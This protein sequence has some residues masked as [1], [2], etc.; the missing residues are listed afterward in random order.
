MVPDGNVVT[1]RP[2]GR[3][4]LTATEQALYIKI[5]GYLRGQLDNGELRPRDRVP[6]EREL[7]DLFGCS[8]APVRQALEMLIN[9]GRI[10]AASGS[11][12]RHVLDFTLLE[13]DQT[14]SESTA[15]LEARL[16]GEVVKD[17]WVADVEGQGHSAGQQIEVHMVK[18]TGDVARLLKLDPGTLV[19]L[20]H[21]MRYVDGF[22]HDVNDT[23]YPMSIAQNTLIQHPDN[24]PQGVI[25]YMAQEL[26]IIQD[27]F[28][29]ELTSRMPTGDEAEGM[30]LGSGVP[31]MVHHHA[32]YAKSQPVK[33][34]VT[35]WPGPATR[36]VWEFPAKMEFPET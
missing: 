36:L 34:T 5:A 21:R 7:M 31:V 19:V 6:T 20:R 33:V 18:A 26:G 1:F 11:A 32:G 14:Q 23:Y 28:R 9:E 30:G 4:A 16:A 25:A 27:R 2:G 10:S 3:M 22:P 24:I 17:A 13:F 15:R 29:D 12:G 35:I 8:R